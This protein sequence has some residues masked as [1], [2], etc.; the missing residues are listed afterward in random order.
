M[1]ISLSVQR[2]QQCFA[3]TDLC[4]NN[5][6][7]FIRKFEPPVLLFEYCLGLMKAAE[8]KLQERMYL[9]PHPDTVK[10]ETLYWASVKESLPNW[11]EFL[12]GRAEYPIADNII[13][14]I[15]CNIM[16]LNGNVNHL[17]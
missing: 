3:A 8:K 17:K 5:I 14:V 15:E 6:Y 11:E 13:Q 9:L 4:G 16:P 7:S 2:E 12:L 1:V 10:L